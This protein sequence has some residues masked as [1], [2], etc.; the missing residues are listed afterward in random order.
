VD[1]MQPSPTGGQRDLATGEHRDRTTGRSVAPG[2]GPATDSGAGLTPAGV[3]D[4]VNAAVR[5]IPEGY[6]MTYGDI[7]RLLGLKTPRQV[8]S[9]LARGSGSTPWHRVVHADGTLV[10]GLMS[11]QSRLL[12]SEGVEVTGGRVDIRRYRW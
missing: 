7:A 5:A 8:G 6:V 10:Q 1:R 12:R 2:A 9:V 11:E 4:R 3:I